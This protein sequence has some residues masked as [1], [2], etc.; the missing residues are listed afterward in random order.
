[1][2][3]RAEEDPHEHGSPAAT[4]VRQPRGAS[5]TAAASGGAAG[6][7]GVARVAGAAGVAGVPASPGVAG[8]ARVAGVAGVAGDAGLDMVGGEAGGPA[9][10]E[11]G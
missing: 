2:P 11:P 9:G 5:F 3:V 4:L 7:A 8:V 6:V 10:R 1:M